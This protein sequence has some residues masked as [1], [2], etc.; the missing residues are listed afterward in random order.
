MLTTVVVAILFQS[1]DGWIN[2]HKLPTYWPCPIS[3]VKGR[4]QMIPKGSG[5]DVP[6]FTVKAGLEIQTR[7]YIRNCYFCSKDEK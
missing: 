3:E 6:G 2:L 4:G 1:Q 5:S 7:F